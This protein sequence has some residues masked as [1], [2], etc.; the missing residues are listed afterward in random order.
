MSTKHESQTF[1]MSIKFSQAILGNRYLNIR[2]VCHIVKYF[3]YG[4][5]IISAESL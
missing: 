4:Y 2:P 1:I 5:K 3:I